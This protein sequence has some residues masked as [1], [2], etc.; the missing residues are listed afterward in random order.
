MFSNTS[1]GR[2]VSRRKLLATSATALGMLAIAGTA[3][4]ASAHEFKVGDLELVHPWTRATPSGAKVA[5]GFVTIKNTG[6]ASD[7][8]IGGTVDFA[9]KVEVHEMSMD[10]GVMKMRQLESGLE[11]PAGQETDLKPGG[12]HIMF[13]GLKR[14][15]AEGETAKGTLV[16]EKAGSVDV[17]W[18]V[19]SIGA[20]KP[21][22]AMDMGQPGGNGAGMGE[23]KMEHKP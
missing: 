4:T 9:E 5:G 7:R 2:V 22:N 14:G 19:E 15:L 3:G 10:N 1:F 8:L 23:M 11:L 21:A 12:Y 16:F 18:A 6:A 20:R 17:E 13:T